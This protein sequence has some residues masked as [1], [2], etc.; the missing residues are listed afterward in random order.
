MKILPD[1]VFSIPVK[2]EMYFL[3]LLQEIVV[4]VNTD[5]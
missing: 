5:N 3:G 4:A 1:C 2:F